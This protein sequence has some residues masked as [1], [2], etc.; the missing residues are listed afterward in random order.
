MFQI[1]E[2]F[3]KYNNLF[4]SLIENKAEIKDLPEADGFAIIAD[5]K[6]LPKEKLPPEIIENCTVGS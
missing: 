4:D 2:E 6:S 5:E 1:K 3:L